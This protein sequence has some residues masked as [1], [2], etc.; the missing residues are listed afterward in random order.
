[1]KYWSTQHMVGRSVGLSTWL[2]IVWPVTASDGQ[3]LAQP[4]LG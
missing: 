2:G 3:L 1:M 4:V